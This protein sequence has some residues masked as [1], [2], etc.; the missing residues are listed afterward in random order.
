MVEM[1]V[2]KTGSVPKLAP[3]RCGWEFGIGL[4]T[5]IQPEGYKKK[6]ELTSLKQSFLCSLEFYI[7]RTEGKIEY[8]NP[9]ITN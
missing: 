1:V 2:M 3:V 4:T 6:N 8:A 9:W 5:I 7:L